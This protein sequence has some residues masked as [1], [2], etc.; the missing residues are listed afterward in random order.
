MAANHASLADPP[1]VGSSLHRP[2]YFMAKEELFRVPILGFLIK[3]VNAFP[4][5]RK[6]GDVG[7]FRTA[8]EILNSGG[9]LTV[10]PEGR[11][12]RNGRMGRPRAG[13]ALLAA[14][15]GAPVVPVYVHNT[16]KL[17]HFPR[18]TV[19]FG[20]PLRIGENE[21]HETFAH[22]IMEQIGK[23]KETYFGPT[24]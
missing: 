9:A 20:S 22:R 3:R 15:T 21:N 7:A 2:V 10:F 11:R 8:Q 23:L 12:Q 19:L 1:L 6:E 13:V 4:I 16:N 18:L 24:H 17:F 5:R 14:K